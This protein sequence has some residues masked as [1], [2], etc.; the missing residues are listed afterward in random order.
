MIWDLLLVCLGMHWTSV[1]PPN[2][3]PSS[4]PHKNPNHICW[5]ETEVVERLF[6]FSGVAGGCDSWET[7]ESPWFKWVSLVRQELQSQHRQFQSLLWLYVEDL[8]TKDTYIK[9]LVVLPP[10]YSPSIL[11]P[12]TALRNKNSHRSSNPTHWASYKNLLSKLISWCLPFQWDESSHLPRGFAE[13]LTVCK[14]IFTKLSI[15]QHWLNGPCP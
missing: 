8:K 15:P 12:A 3:A 11:I 14:F 10:K 7:Q 2:T 1:T 6:W 13:N 5:T 9:P 4:S